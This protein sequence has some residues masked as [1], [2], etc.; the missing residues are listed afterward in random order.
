MKRRGVLIGINGFGYYWR[1]SFIPYV[2]NVEGKMD[3]VGAYNR[4]E[5]GFEDAQKDLGLRPDQCFTDIRQMLERTRP[6]FVMIVVPPQA[7]EP[8]IDLAL[9][10]GCD[11]ITEKPLALDME[12]CVRI[13]R[14][15]ERLGK[16]LCVTMTHRMARD[17]QTLLR[18][19]QSGAHGPVANISGILTVARQDADYADT[20]RQHM[21]YYYMFDA[22]IHQ[23]DIL[24]ALSRSNARTL[25]CKGWAPEWA[26]FKQV[27][28]YNVIAEME[29]GVICNYQVSSCS[30]ANLNWWYQDY[31]RVD[32]RDSVLE[33]NNQKLTAHRGRKI[34]W[35]AKMN[36][37]RENI[38]IDI[39]LLGGERWTNTLLLSQ[40]IDWINGGNPPVTDVRDNLYSMAMLF[41]AI[42]SMQTGREID[43]RALCHAAFAQ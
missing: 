25:Y 29:N 7:R 10:Y 24:R 11:I 13:A 41:S 43:V 33:L 32:C 6:D 8:V 39:P 9:E 4:S 35:D 15:V 2:A 16:K 20:W 23:L 26:A 1:K 27:A 36:I 18:E 28:A 3:V 12:A 40:F 21:D 42:E 37:T 14:K 34:S 31:I 17:K 5:K 19:I 30:A 38:D 22:A